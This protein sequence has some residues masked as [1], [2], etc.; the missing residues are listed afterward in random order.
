M[1]LPIQASRSQQGFTLIELTIVLVTIGV[2]SAIAIPSFLS[3]QK[4]AKTAEAMA[5]L[6]SLFRGAAAYYNKQVSVP[7]PANSRITQVSHCITGDS[8]RLPAT[9]GS[10]KQ[11]GNFDSD[12]T[13]K[14]LSFR[15]ADPVYFAYEVDGA[16]LCTAGPNIDAYTFFAYG[17]LD[18]DGTFS[19]FSFEAATNA[20]LDLVRAPGVNITDQTE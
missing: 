12:R 3:Y 2:L 20:E 4:R 1:S 11:D 9:P 7:D 10:Q 8:V 13:F 17:D 15:L 5:N 18:D 16:N 19:T 6:P 14:A